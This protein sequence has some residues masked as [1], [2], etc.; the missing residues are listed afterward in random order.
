[1]NTNMSSRSETKD[2]RHPASRKRYAGTSKLK[3]LAAV[4]LVACMSVAHAA[5]VDLGRPEIQKNNATSDWQYFAWKLPVRNNTHVSKYVTIEIK[6]I[7]SA[8]FEVENVL[9]GQ[10]IPARTVLVFTG[11]DSVRHHDWPRIK[12]LKP[13]LMLVQNTADTQ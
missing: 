5:D 4:L 3:I 10:D 9:H 8:G 2:D 7:D 1:M 6:L 13:I 11:R 12:S